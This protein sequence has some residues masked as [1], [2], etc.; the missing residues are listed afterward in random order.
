MRNRSELVQACN[1]LIKTMPV[2]YL[3]EC[4]RNISEDYEFYLDAK[5]VQAGKS[6]KKDSKYRFRDDEEE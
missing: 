4:F 1:D 6:N 2:D 5:K 3:E